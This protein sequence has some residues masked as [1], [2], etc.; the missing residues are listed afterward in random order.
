MFARFSQ[1]SRWCLAITLLAFA[2]PLASGQGVLVDLTPQRIVPLPRPIVV[3]RPQPPERCYQV[4]SI[5]VD[6]KVSGQ[7][8]KVRMRQTFENTGSVAME[9]VFVFPLPYDGAIDGMTLMVGEREYP[10]KL[11][12]AEEARKLYEEIVRKNKDPALLEWLGKGLFRTSAFPLPAGEKRTV[13]ISYTQICRQTNGL[14][15][16][17]IPLRAA[18]YTTSPLDLLKIKVAIE[19]DSAIANIYSAD[20]DV[21]IER[22]GPKHAV[23]TYEAKDKLPASDFRLFFDTAADEVGTSVISY[24]PDK[25]EPGYFLLLAGAAIDKTRGGQVKN[26]TVV[27]AIDRSGSMAGEK[28][29][30]AKGA[31]KFVLNNLRKGDTFNIVAYDSEVESFRPEIQKFDDETRQAALGYVEGLFA[32][33]STNLAGAIKRSMEMLQDDNRPS[34]VIFLTDGLPT[35]GEVKEAAI[36]KQSQ[37]ANQVRAR[38]FSFGCGYDVNSRLLDRLANENHGRSEFV[39]PNEDIERSVSQLYQRI[40][41]PVL[42]DVELTFDVEGQTTADGPLVVHR[43]PKGKFDM[44]AGEQTVILGRYKQSGA[45]KGTLEGT[46]GDGERKFSFAADLVEK[47]RDDTNAFVAKLWAARR[48]GEIIDELDLNGKNEELIKELVDL[49]TKHGILTQYTSFMADDSEVL[50][51][52]PG[53]LAETERRAADQLSTTEGEFGVNQRYAKGNLRRLDRASEAAGGQAALEGLP[54]QERQALGAATAAGNLSFYDSRQGRARA[55]ENMLQVGRKTFFRSGN[56]WVDTT[57]AAGEEESARRIERYSEE[58]FELA[59]RHGD[60]VGPLLAIEGDVVVKL[61]G[62]V[63]AW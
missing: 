59:E 14:S 30:Q 21:K 51:N 48:A 15:D 2:P 7:V 36:V 11:L 23:V 26:K 8:A 54:S 42:T 25:D 32:G 58:Y 45:A 47:S 34:Y 49:A 53:M 52:R 50:R 10:A 16:L 6:A 43:Y 33:G 4:E 27:F 28:I 57:V 39:R 3:P 55:A 22:S 13:D 1:L 31:L 38:L 35:V 56:R 5:E 60:Y 63:Y 61:E 62:T 37:E 17:V 41:A 44:F 18:R 12:K 24:R 19:S 29:E 9:V 20:H 40:E 46:L